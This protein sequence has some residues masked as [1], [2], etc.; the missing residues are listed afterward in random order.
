MQIR[1]KKQML[2]C[3]IALPFAWIGCDTDESST[4]GNVDP[5][6]E[7]GEVTGEE[8]ESEADSSSLTIAFAD[9]SVVSGGMSDH[10]LGKAEVI[11][12]DD[13]EESIFF[14]GKCIDVAVEDVISCE[15]NESCGSYGGTNASSEPLIDDEEASTG[16]PSVDQNPESTVDWGFEEGTT[17]FQAKISK[18]W[19][20]VIPDELENEDNVQTT[21]V[22]SGSEIVTMVWLSFYRHVVIRANQPMEA[23]EECEVSGAIL[24]DPECSTNACAEFGNLA[25]FIQAGGTFDILVQGDAAAVDDDLT[26]W[27]TSSEEPRSLADVQEKLGAFMKGLDG[28]VEVDTEDYGA[29]LEAGAKL[30][31]YITVDFSE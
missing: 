10:I 11:A 14:S 18:T 28:E 24:L 29:M 17:R 22:C 4:T 21:G 5:I 31:D 15:E 25:N 23:C 13:G 1:W 19:A 27:L 8:G 16:L 2:L 6:S 9:V 3:A 26:S 7:N 20:Y 30:S 12:S